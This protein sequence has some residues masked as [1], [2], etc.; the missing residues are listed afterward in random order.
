MKNSLRIL[1]S[2]I[3]ISTT[4]TLNG[5]S[6][7]QESVA[8]SP[9]VSSVWGVGEIPMAELNARYTNDHSK[10]MSFAGLR[11]HYQDEGNP[12]GQPIVLLHGMLS[13]LGTWDEWKKGLL[14]DYRV[15]SLDVPGFGLTGGPENEEDYNEVLLHAS[16]QHFIDELELDDFVLAGNSLGG[17]MSAHYAANNPN[18]VKKLILIDPAGAP[19]DMPFFLNLASMPVVNSVVSNVLPTIFISLAVKDAYGEEERITEESVQRYIDFSLKPGAR[20]AYANSI[21]LVSDK[22]DRQEPLDFATITAPTLLMWGDEDRW[23]PTELSQLWLDNIPNSSLI[24]YPNVGHAPMEE[25][26]AQSLSDA[27]AFIQ[28]P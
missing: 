20:T 21:A 5:C 22:N 12:D 28:Q 19:Q 16:F 10:W 26:P 9:D 4:L 25:I 23:V 3:I 2:G 1:M 8:L 7:L 27:I 11:M 17:Y 18:K 13:S 6:S 15:I 24:T 14:A